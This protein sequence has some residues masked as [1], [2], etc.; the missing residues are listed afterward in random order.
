MSETIILLRIDDG[1]GGPRAFYDMATPADFPADRAG[2][3]AG[4]AMRELAST[5]EIYRQR[6]TADQQRAFDEAVVRA[7]GG[8]SLVAFQQITIAD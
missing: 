7:A 5:I 3:C 1:A 8:E 4:I 6:L 2:Q